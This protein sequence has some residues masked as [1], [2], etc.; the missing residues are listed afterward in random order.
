[1]EK[2][3]ERKMKNIEDINRESVQKILTTKKYLNFL[4][5]IQLKLVLESLKEKEKESNILKA[6][7]LQK[8][9]EV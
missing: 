8:K 6:F 7:V 9:I 3:Q 5:G 1:M 2:A 4:L